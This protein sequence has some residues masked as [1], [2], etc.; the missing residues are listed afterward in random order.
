M[1]QVKVAVVGSRTE[2]VTLND[3]ATVSE[4][5]SAAG[6]SADNLDIRI[7]GNSARLTTKVK[8]GDIIHLVARAK[9]GR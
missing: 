4:A 3:G 1:I 7:D 8:D 2:E 9:G 6:R 5:L